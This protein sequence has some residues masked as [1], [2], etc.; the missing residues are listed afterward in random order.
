[1]QLQWLFFMLFFSS[2]SSEQLFA[3]LKRRGCLI[4][5]P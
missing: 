5:A 2:C 3:E 4:G 1:M